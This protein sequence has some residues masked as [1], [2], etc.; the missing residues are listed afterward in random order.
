MTEKEVEE[1]I[2]KLSSVYATL[3]AL[4]KVE[5]YPNQVTEKIKVLEEVMTEIKSMKNKKCCDTCKYYEWYYD[6]CN[7]Y[8][9]EVDDRSVCSS[10]EEQKKKEYV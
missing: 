1:I 7:K 5:R 6:K 2:D 10:H 8:N 9:C 4:K 3:M